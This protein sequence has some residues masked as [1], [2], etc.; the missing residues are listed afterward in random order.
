MEYVC[1]FF[2]FVYANYEHQHVS[3]QDKSTYILYTQ[4]DKVLYL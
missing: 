1:Q 3:T 2:L 4:F